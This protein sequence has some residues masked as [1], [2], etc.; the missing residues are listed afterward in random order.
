VFV[1]ILSRLLNYSS[2]VGLC[3]LRRVSRTRIGGGE[4]ARSVEKRCSFSFCRNR[5]I[6]RWDRAGYRLQ[7]VLSLSSVRP[8]SDRFVSPPFVPL[9]L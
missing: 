3:A 6:E 5:K 2:S 1:I 9:I 4:E 8:R 7:V